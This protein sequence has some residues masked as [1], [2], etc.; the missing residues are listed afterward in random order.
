[1]AKRIRVPY[2]FT[3]RDYQMNMMTF[4]DQGFKRYVGVVHRRG[5]KDKAM[6]NV[7]ISQ[8]VQRPA[9]YYHIFPTYA[10]GRKA[11]WEGI[12]PR[13]GIKML[14]HFPE[15]LI[16]RK[17]D[18][19]M[20][21]ELQNR[22]IYRV[23]GIENY[24]DIMGTNPYGC[25]FSEYSLQDPR[26]WDYIRPILAENGGWAAFIYTFRGR[27]HGWELYEMARTRRHEGWLTELLTIKDTRREDGSY[28]ISPEDVEREI[29]EGM[30]PAF[31][32]QEYYCSP[33]GMAMGAYYGKQLAAAREEQR[34]GIVPYIAGHKVDTFWDL[35]YDDS[36]TIWFMQAIGDQFR[37]IDYYENSNEG[38]DHYAKIIHQKPYVYGDFYFP[39]DIANHDIGIEGGKSRME[40]AESYGLR[41]AVRIKRPRDTASVRDGIES[42]RGLFNRCV[43][44]EKKCSRGL[45]ALAGYEADYDEK[46]KKLQNRP[47][48]NW[49]SHGADAFR[50]FAMGFRQRTRVITVSQHLGLGK[51]A[52]VFG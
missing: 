8:A 49:C 29:A 44:D 28:V 41:P 4:L 31:A 3:P 27:N 17:N 47:K 15:E 16:S 37:F 13:T 48:H 9:I 14:D 25:V 11:I 26:A 6:L 18:Q 30:D 51:T 5:G 38:L 23:I 22:S 50:T 35:G 10:Q 24:N 52:T 36:T 40:V 34:I 46:Q 2:K 7:I 45:M 20:R 21:I 39:H 1:M 32:Q 42:A 12:D 33:E 19:E 43:F